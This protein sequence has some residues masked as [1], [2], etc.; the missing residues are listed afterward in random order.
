MNTRTLL[1]IAAAGALAAAPFVAA[2]HAH[3]DT[4]DVAF[5]ATLADHGI[6]AGTGAQG[7]IK[8]GHAVCR[9]LADGDTPTM[10]TALVAEANPS[11]SLTNAAY[12]VGV[13]V[14]AYC[15]A[16]APASWSAGT[17]AA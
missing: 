3:A 6:D 9:E 1:Y 5:L 2:G 8:A 11:L 12:F 10:V 16:L 14:G 7:L 17:E 4:N 13:A 15:P